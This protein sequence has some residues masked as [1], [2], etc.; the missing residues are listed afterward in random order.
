M[1]S[2]AL[3][4]RLEKVR[5]TG[6][7]KWQARCPAHDDR[8]P[9]L[10]IRE[11]DD[12]RILLHDFGGCGVEEVLG[13]MGLNMFELFPERALVDHFPRERRPFLPSDVFEIARREVGIVAIIACDMHKARSIS[14][15]DYERLFTAVERLNEIAGAAYDR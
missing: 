3:L 1:S 10:S 15:S 9:S 13:A 2:D 8:S 12:G 5:R 6:P 4:S 14:E 11:L 7:G